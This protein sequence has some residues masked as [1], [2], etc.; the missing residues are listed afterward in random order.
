MCG[1]SDP[2]QSISDTLAS[3]D[4]GPSIGSGLASL[5]SA[6]SQNV[7]GGWGSIAALAAAIATAGASIP[8]SE[9]EFIAA[10]AGNLAAQG[11]SQEAIAQNLAASYSI[12]AADAATAAAATNAGAAETFSQTGTLNPDFVNPNAAPT[13][14]P[15]ASNLPSLSDPSL[16]T[17][18]GAPTSSGSTFGS[19]SAPLDGS[20]AIPGAGA[21]TSSSGLTGALPAGTM[22]GDGTAGT[23]MGVTY[24]DAGGGVPALDAFGNP[25]PATSVGIEGFAPSSSLSL[26]DL[27]NARKAY[28]LAKSLLGTGTAATAT[29]SGLSSVA[30]QASSSSGSSGL[31]T[32]TSA[33]KGTFVQGKQVASPL[34]SKFD[35]P[36]EPI[37]GSGSASNPAAEMA[38]IQNA[39]TGGIMHLAGGG[40]DDELSMKPVLMRGKHA[41]HSNLFG[42]GGI[43]LFPTVSKATGGSIPENFSPQFYSEGGLGSMKHA[44]V[45]GAGTGT[46]DSIPAMLSNGEFVIPADV[47]SSLGDGSNDSG[48]KILDS[49]LTT[50]RSHKQKHDAKHLPAQS[51][52]ALGYLLEA[53]RK[54]KK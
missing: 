35:I 19:I 26:S 50:I 24:V 48:A 12:S 34:Q 4:P 18:I 32:T 33:P 45:R 17:Q 52:G 39:A 20:G 3:V 8:A 14:T 29:K 16:T 53:K 46:S 36:I 9:A 11:L 13:P 54:V 31:D 25:I 38:L 30:P 22:V 5:D 27:N 2:I 1:G 40:S 44:Y 21:T 49:F 43:P 15:S 41:E 37:S 42:L 10:D 6:V 47:V 51:K 7:P 23:T 28:G